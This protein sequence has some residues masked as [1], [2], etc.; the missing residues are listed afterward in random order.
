M[1]QLYLGFHLVYILPTGTA[2]TGGL[3]FDIGRIDLNI[4]GIIYQRIDVYRYERCMS[5]GITVERRNAHQSV[6]TAFPFQ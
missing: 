2:T 1:G 4:D 5:A 6:Y 3:H